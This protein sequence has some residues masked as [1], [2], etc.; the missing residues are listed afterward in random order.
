M[1]WTGVSA[2]VVGRTG[3]A[4]TAAS[5]CDVDAVVEE[6]ACG[7]LD[8]PVGMAPWSCRGAAEHTG[9]GSGDATGYDQQDRAANEPGAATP[10]PGPRSRCVTR[11]AGYRRC[12]VEP[13]EAGPCLPPVGEFGLELGY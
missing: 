12:R 8:V 9:Y 13:P 10:P 11:G 6:G 5:A 2:A 1:L 4:E 3:D 7:A